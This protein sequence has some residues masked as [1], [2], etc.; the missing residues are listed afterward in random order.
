[1]RQ[2][3]SPI[4]PGN[5]S[6]TT[7]PMRAQ[8]RVKSLPGPAMRAVAMTGPAPAH[9]RPRQTWDPAKENDRNKP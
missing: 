6:T 1:M 9:A 7:T 3:Q 8:A 4:E 2:I 5:P